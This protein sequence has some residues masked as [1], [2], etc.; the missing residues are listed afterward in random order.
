MVRKTHETFELFQ[1]NAYATIL[2][3]ID[4]KKISKYVNKIKPQEHRIYASNIGGWHSHYFYYPFPACVLDLNKKIEAF[5][6]KTI[7]KDMECLGDTPIH[8]SW[9]I[10]NKK[11]DFNKPHKHPPYTF[12]AV[13][14]VKAP[15]DSG[16]IIF[17]NQIG[18]LHLIYPMNF[19]H[20]L[21]ILNKEN[22][23]EKN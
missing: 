20:M 8:N 9:F 10:S 16:R 11:C 18:K 13:Y 23:Y 4:N 1:T 3:G 19:K 12:A 21:G 14:Y 6:R 2:K 17:N 22:Y 5:V 7:R 15:E